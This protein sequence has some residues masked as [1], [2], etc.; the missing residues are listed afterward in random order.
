MLKRD[1]ILNYELEEKLKS[2]W[3]NERLLGGKIMTGFAALR[4][5]TYSFST[6]DNEK[7][8]KSKSTRKYAIK[9]ELKL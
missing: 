3:I 1:L 6:D 5:K 8:K 2:N 9:Q 4:P 7:N